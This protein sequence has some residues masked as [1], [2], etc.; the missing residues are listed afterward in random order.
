MLTEVLQP[1]FQRDLDRL[2]TEIG[3]YR[4][5][6]NLWRVSGQVPNSAGNLCLHLIGNLNTYLGAILGGSGYVRDRPREFADRDVPRAELLAAVAATRQMV[7]Q[8]LG[9]L[10]PAQLAEDYPVPVFDHPM[11]TEYFLVHLLAHLGYHLGQVNYHRRLLDA[12]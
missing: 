6:A 10:T 5:E 8:V 11:T 1:M 9:R 2:H 3:L 4:T 12:S 7:G